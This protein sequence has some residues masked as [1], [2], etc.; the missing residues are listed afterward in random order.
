VKFGVGNRSDLSFRW[1]FLA[2]LGYWREQDVLPHPI[3]ELETL[4]GSEKTQRHG[5]LAGPWLRGLSVT[6]TGRT[7]F[8][9]EG[10]GKTLPI[11]YIGN[12]SIAGHLCG[13]VT[14]TRGRPARA[15]WKVCR[16]SLCRQN[17][18]PNMK[19]RRAEAGGAKATPTERSGNVAGHPGSPGDRRVCCGCIRFLCTRLSVLSAR[20]MR[21]AGASRQLLRAIRCW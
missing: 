10:E 2:W 1:R 12:R 4:K 14:G 9:L 11:T 8:V 20:S 16:R 5:V 19:Q 21:L 7:D 15:R 17:V 13:Q 6:L 3:A 18:R